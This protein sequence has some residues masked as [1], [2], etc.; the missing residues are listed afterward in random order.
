MSNIASLFLRKR[1]RASDDERGLD[2]ETS[3]ERSFPFSTRMGVVFFAVRDRDLFQWGVKHAQRLRYTRG[4]FRDTCTTVIGARNGRLWVMDDDESHPREL[5][6]DNQFA[7]QEQYGFIVVRG[8][9]RDELAP[10]PVPE[11]WSREVV[12]FLRTAPDL[13]LSFGEELR[14]VLYV[15]PIVAPN[16][17]VGWANGG[18][19]SVLDFDDEDHDAQSWKEAI[20]SASFVIPADINGSGENDLFAPPQKKL[21]TEARPSVAAGPIDDDGTARVDED[22]DGHEAV[23]VPE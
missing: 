10:A 6:E 16:G 1:N 17:A 5:D 22:D 13:K 4:F 3:T 15:S 8:T 9:G 12:N 7:L 2:R 21:R 18:A 19:V 23:L 20:A 14:S 11:T